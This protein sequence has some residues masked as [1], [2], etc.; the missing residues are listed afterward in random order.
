M[1]TRLHAEEKSIGGLISDADALDA[2][3]RVELLAEHV[4][5]SHAAL[6][7]P[8]EQAHALNSPRGFQEMRLLLRRVDDL[9]GR[10]VAQRPVDAPSQR[11]IKEGPQ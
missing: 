6:L 5:P 3:V 9:L 8:P 2:Q 7:G 11:R 10:G 1:I 4:H